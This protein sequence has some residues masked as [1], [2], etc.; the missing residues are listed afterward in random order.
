MKLQVKNKGAWKDVL[1]FSDQHLDAVLDAVKKLI[2]IDNG[3]KTAFRILD[4]D[5]DIVVYIDKCTFL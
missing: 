3:L 4:K 5:G 2:D 1:E